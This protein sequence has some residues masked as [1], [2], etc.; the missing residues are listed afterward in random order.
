MAIFLL[1]RRETKTH[2]EERLPT[3]RPQDLPARVPFRRP[4]PQGSRASCPVLGGKG[5]RSQNR[6]PEVL[7][8]GHNK[9]GTPLTPSLLYGLLSGLRPVV[10]MPVPKT[11]DSQSMARDLWGSPRSSLCPPCI[12][13]R[14]DWSDNTHPHTECTAGLG[15]QLSPIKPHT[16]FAKIQNKANLLH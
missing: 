14:L 9:P 16:R 10:S 15:I 13:S 11:S 3:P 2:R 1:K 7:S 8:V 12:C 6:A 5:S 4:G